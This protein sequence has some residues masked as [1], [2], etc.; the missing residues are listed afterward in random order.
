MI[1]W[2]AQWDAFHADDA[3]R[4]VPVHVAQLV[5]L[6]VSSIGTFAGGWLASTPP[7][8]TWTRHRTTHGSGAER[9]ARR[10]SHNV[11][12]YL[13]RRGTVLLVFGVIW[14][15]IASGV[16]TGASEEIIDPNTACSTC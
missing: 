6:G 7:A 15:L 8:Q 2:G 16:A 9:A 10:I 14:A 11:A 13:G 3:L 5:L 4:A 12:A 1:V